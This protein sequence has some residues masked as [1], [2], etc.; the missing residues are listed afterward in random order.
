MGNGGAFGEPVDDQ[1]RRTWSQQSKHTY[2]AALY[3]SEVS[4]RFCRRC[5]SASQFDSTSL[6]N[7]HFSNCTSAID[8]N[9]RPYSSTSKFWPVSMRNVSF[10]NSS[11][12]SL[13]SV[14]LAAFGNLLMRD[15]RTN[16]SNNAREREYERFVWV[17]AYR[18]H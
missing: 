4:M 11:T 10:D 15:C 18:W 12:I 6:S 8:I 2:Q 3:L 14:A 1:Q 16:A 17:V 7:V 5:P 13:D 9:N